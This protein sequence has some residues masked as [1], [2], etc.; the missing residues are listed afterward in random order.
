MGGLS[1]AGLTTLI[2]WACLD[3][4]GEMLAIGAGVAAAVVVGLGIWAMRRWRRQTTSCATEADTSCACPKG[5][6]Q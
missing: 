4:G 2:D 1:V 6:N 5:V 3:V